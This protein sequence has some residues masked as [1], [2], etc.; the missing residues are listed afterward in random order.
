MPKM[1]LHAVTKGDVAFWS[2]ELT[3]GHYGSRVIGDV[4]LYSDRRAKEPARA[5]H[6]P[7]PQVKKPDVL[8]QMAVRVLVEVEMLRLVT[9]EV[10]KANKKRSD[11][12]PSGRVKP[13]WISNGMTASSVTGT[14]ATSAT[15]SAVLQITIMAHF[16]F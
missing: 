3:R 5:A 8:L 4:V 2:M 1:Q 13:D 7:V 9:V 15:G 10:P 12:I 16:G 11:E 6:L 14:L